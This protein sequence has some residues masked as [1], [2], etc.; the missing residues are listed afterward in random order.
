MAIFGWS[1]G[2]YAALQAG[3]TEP[4]L[5][6][7]VV[8]IAP[9][10]DLQQAKDDFRDYTNARNLADISAR[11]HIARGLPAQNAGDPRAGA[12]LPRRPRSQRDVV[13]SPRM[14]SALRGAG[15]RSELVVF[16]GLEHDLADSRTGQMLQRI[17]T[18]L[19]AELG[20][21]P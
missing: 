4:A 3:V 20:S 12:A 8:A 14:D 6:K 11:P 2:G 5:F 10:T 21:R 9:V 1:Y 18:F 19:S 17:G 7:A 15:K 16:P 13:H